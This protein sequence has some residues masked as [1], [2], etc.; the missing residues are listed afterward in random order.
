MEREKFKCPKCGT[1]I[2]VNL[3][4]FVD[5][6]ENPEYKTQIMNGQFFFGEVPKLRR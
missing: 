6:T 2:T 3:K 5:V 1:E 4:E